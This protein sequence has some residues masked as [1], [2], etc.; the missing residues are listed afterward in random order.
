MKPT[1][2]D[3][4]GVG[5]MCVFRSKNELKIGRILQFSHYEEKKISANQY[6]GQFAH[7]NRRDLGV[8]CTWLKESGIGQ[9]RMCKDESHCFLPLQ[10][11]ICTLSRQCVENTQND[12]L[13]SLEEFTLTECCREFIL[14]HLSAGTKSG[15][16]SQI[17]PQ[18]SGEQDSMKSTQ[19]SQGVSDEVDSLKPTE[20][21]SQS[22]S[23]EVN[24]QKPT[25]QQLQSVSGEVNSLKPTEQQSQSVSGEVD[26]Q[27]PTEQQSQSVSDNTES[28]KPTDSVVKEQPQE[29]GNRASERHEA[30]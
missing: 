24:S 30:C 5:D 29:A 12:T 25:E 21:Q 22:V 8:L 3:R 17:E 14:C 23:G 1:V 18:I 9:Y 16:H 19:Q 4:V 2:C 10:Q 28:Q 15:G 7:T 13:A 11:Y 6:H 20:Q 26:S 27:K